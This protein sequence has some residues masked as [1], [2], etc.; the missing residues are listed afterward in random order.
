ML[1]QLFLAT[2]LILTLCTVASAENWPQWRGP[3]GD[4][5][6]TEQNLPTTWSRTD[7]VRWHIALP[8]P[9]IHRPSC[10]AI[11]CWSASRSTRSS[12]AR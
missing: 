9:A 7:N 2:C 4:G 10:G 12:A 3:H 8:S 6:T 11:A 1:K 5:V